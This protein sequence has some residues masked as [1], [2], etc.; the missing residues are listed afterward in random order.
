M[1]IGDAT[2]GR[3]GG[4]ITRAVDTNMTTGAGSSGPDVDI[5]TIADT[6]ITG[7][8]DRPTAVGN[9]TTGTAIRSSTAST[10]PTGTGM[11]RTGAMVGDRHVIEWGLRQ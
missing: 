11:G 4:T 1:R 9:R 5:S 7:F 10:D 2:T 6:A 3:N 8:N